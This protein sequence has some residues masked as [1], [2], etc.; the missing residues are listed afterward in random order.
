MK[1]LPLTLYSHNSV[2]PVQWQPHFVCIPCAVATTVSLCYSLCSG[3]HTLSVFFPVQW[4]PHSVLFPVQ[5]QPRSLSIPCAVAKTLYYSLCSGNQTLHYSLCS[6]NHTLSVLF[7]VQWQPNSVFFPVQWQPNSIIP[8]AVVTT[9]CIP[10]AVATTLSL[11]SMCSGSNTLCIISSEVATTLSVLFPVKWKPQS[12]CIPCAVATTL[13]Y[14]LWSG[15][16][17]LTVFHVQRQPKASHQHD[18]VD[19]VMK[20][21]RPLRALC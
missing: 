5:W 13:Y 11:Y 7:P 9:L 12:L 2:F 6:G 16:H 10:C 8:C 14:S 3:N 19:T 18:Q 17:T 20:P 21:H 15:N 4:Q 1:L